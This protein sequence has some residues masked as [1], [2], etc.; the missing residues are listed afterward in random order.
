MNSFQKHHTLKINITIKLN[1]PENFREF[2]EAELR[3]AIFDEVVSFIS[4]QHAEQAVE[5]CSK[6]MKEVADEN[7]ITLNLWRHH[8]EWSEITKQPKFK[9]KVVKE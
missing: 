7:K 9:I 2:S 6:L 5:W 1:L 8:R 4:Q 3:Q